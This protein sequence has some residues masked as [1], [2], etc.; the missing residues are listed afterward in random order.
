MSRP[1]GG[2]SVQLRVERHL[3]LNGCDTS[4]IW[5]YSQVGRK[6][7]FYSQRATLHARAPRSRV[8]PHVYSIGNNSKRVTRFFLF[9]IVEQERERENI[10]L[11]KPQEL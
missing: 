11:G 6:C 9:T 2:R 5:T 10:R 7:C 1:K 4:L 8:I 3:N